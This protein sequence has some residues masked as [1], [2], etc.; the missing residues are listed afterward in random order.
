MIHEGRAITQRA[1]PFSRYETWSHVSGNQKVLGPDTLEL[2]QEFYDTLT[3]HAVPLDPRALAAL[4]H[5]ALVLDVYSWLA[6]P[7]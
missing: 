2:S 7:L 5:S 6:E 1:R 4:R 3:G